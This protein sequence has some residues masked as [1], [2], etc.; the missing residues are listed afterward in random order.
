MCH[1]QTLVGCSVKSYIS[2]NLFKSV[3]ITIILFIQ[4]NVLFLLVPVMVVSSQVGDA[5]RSKPKCKACKKPMKGHKN[6][7]DCPK[8]QKK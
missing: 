4:A 6:V 1:P 5:T 2:F 7:K 8:N 3:V